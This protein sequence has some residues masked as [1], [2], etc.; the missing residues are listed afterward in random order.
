MCAHHQASGGFLCSNISFVFSIWFQAAPHRRALRLRAGRQ[1]HRRRSQIVVS[2][3]EF[4][5]LPPDCHRSA[6][7]TPNIV[8]VPEL[9][10]ELAAISTKTALKTRGENVFTDLQMAQPRLCTAGMGIAGNPR[11]AGAGGLQGGI[12]TQCHR[13]VALYRVPLFP[14]MISVVCTVL[15]SQ[16]PFS[17]CRKSLVPTPAPLSVVASVCASQRG[18]ASPAVIAG[19]RYCNPC[20]QDDNYFS[21]HTKTKNHL[22]V[23][24][25]KQPDSQAWVHL[26]RSETDVQRKMTKQREETTKQMFSAGREFVQVPLK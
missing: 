13:R 14:L 23:A 10:P 24:S 26:F 2:W 3:A 16:I 9:A 8:S 25:Y 20:Y 11:T 17:S 7:H 1:C 15:G 6:A 5:E 21:R 12:H 18:P 19:L 4:S 22:N